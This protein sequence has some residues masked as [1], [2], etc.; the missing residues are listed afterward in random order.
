LTSFLL[1]R[2]MISDCHQVASRT[3]SWT[4]QGVRVCVVQ[5]YRLVCGVQ[6]WSTGTVVDDEGEGHA[7]SCR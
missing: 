2:L 1:F 6:V 4:D 3:E 5:P 7:D